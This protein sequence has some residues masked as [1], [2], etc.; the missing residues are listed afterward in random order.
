MDRSSD[1]DEENG[2]ESQGATTAPPSEVRLGVLAD[3]VGFH[4][5]QAQN[6][7][8][9]AYKKRTGDPEVRPG[10]FSVLALIGAN[11]G[12]TPVVLSRASGRDKSTLT[13]ILRDLAHRSLIVR[14]PVLGDRRSYALA[15]TDSGEEKLALLAKHAAIHEHKLDQLAGPAKAELLTQLRRI[16]ALLE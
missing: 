4:L 11:P 3:Y 16:T 15:L 2:P 12:I 5:R 10:W 9:K 8:F 13:P 6:A 7:A 14:M 1:P